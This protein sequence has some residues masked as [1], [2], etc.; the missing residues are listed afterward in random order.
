MT[1]PLIVVPPVA[2]TDAMLTSTDVPEADYAV[3]DGSTTYAEGDRVIRVETH[4]IYESAAS[5]NVGH[6]PETSTDQWIVVGPTNRWAIF[7]TSNSTS[8]RQADGMSYTLALTGAITA[9]ALLN[10][11]A[12]LSVRV[13]LTHTTYGTVYDKTTDVASIPSSSGWWEWFFGT[14]SAPPLAV[15]LDLPGIL[16]CT[17]IVDITGTDDLSLGVMLFG[18]QQPIGLGMLQG[19]RLGI[20][21]Y[22]RVE[23][24]DFGNTLFVQRAFAKRASFEVPVL[25]AAVDQTID[26]L[27]TYRAIPCLWIGGPSYSSS[28][29]YGFYKSFDVVIAYHAVSECSLEIQGLT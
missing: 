6:T 7:D 10:L 14:R 16:G 4:R 22:S 2:V 5:S 1:T 11:Q 18:Q 27:S 29:I 21:D 9:L 3:W 8:T 25:A 28:V 19:A 15:W 17:L 12:A 13:R 24:D 23:T 20:Q 26:F